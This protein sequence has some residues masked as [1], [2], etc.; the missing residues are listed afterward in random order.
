MFKKS[1]KNTQGDLF[2]GVPSILEGKSLGQYN[3]RE[4]WHNQFPDIGIGWHDDIERGLWV[5]RPATVRALPVQLVGQERIGPV[6]PE[7]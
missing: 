2:C 5:E 4:G 1:V 7:R 6:Q 3:N